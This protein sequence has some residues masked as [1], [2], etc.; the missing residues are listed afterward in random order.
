M[1]RNLSATHLQGIL[2]LECTRVVV[3]IHQA[4]QRHHET[5]S[6][7][8]AGRHGVCAIFFSVVTPQATRVADQN[9]SELT[10]LALL[11]RRPLRLQ[12]SHPEQNP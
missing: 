2:C 8:S 1:K 11:P 6:F 9:A 10:T 5:L 4:T 3:S 7:R 12:S